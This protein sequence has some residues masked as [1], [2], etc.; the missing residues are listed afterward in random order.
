MDDSRAVKTPSFKCSSCERLSR[1]RRCACGS[2]AM[3]YIDRRPLLL[4]RQLR[5]AVEGAMGEAI[6]EAAA[7]SDSGRAQ[8]I[9]VY[10]LPHFLHV[11][12][13]HESAVRRQ[14]LDPDG[15]RQLEGSLSK[16][17]AEVSRVPFEEIR[18]RKRPS[19]KPTN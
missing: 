12:R 7:T 1:R 17:L 16:Q 18:A 4:S 19:R 10:V 2:A 8:L 11:L 3:P 13:D 6:C 14:R 15:F 9:R 5:D